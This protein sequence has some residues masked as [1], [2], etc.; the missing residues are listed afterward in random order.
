MHYALGHIL[1]L[2]APIIPL[3]IGFA[4]AFQIQCAK[5]AY[6]W[7]SPLVVAAALGYIWAFRRKEA[8]L[9]RFASANLLRHILLGVSPTRQVVKAVLLMLALVFLVFALVEPQMGY[10]WHELKRMGVDIMIAVDTSKSMLATDV[11]PT[12]LSTAK[13]KIEDLVN[14]LDGDRIGLVA[15]AGSAFI[16]CPLTLDYGA[17]RTIL[18]S[19]DPDTIPLPGTAIGK[20]IH[21]CLDAFDQRERKHKV[22][23]LITDGEDHEGEG[24]PIEAAKR[25]REDGVPVYTVGVG[26]PGGG[27]I[28]LKDERG[29]TFS[30]KAKDG[31][32]VKSHLDEKALLLIAEIS[33]GKFA[34]ANSQKW[35]LERIYHEK[36]EEME[37]RELAAKKLKRYEHR[38]QYPLAIVFLLLIIEPF[39]SERRKA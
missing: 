37:E 31:S 11:T 26:T 24:K 10:K 32:A 2:L 5:R 3:L 21:K 25:A 30:L 6:L 33:R 38:F 29:N 28:T 36:I 17:F 22:V 9:Q 4:L 27:Y 23:I 13:R 14:I 34:R 19:I 12:R 1:A 8:L 35:P 7:L 39:V 16:Q 18:D 20:A 15:F